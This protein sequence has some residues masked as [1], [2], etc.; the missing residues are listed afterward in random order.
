MVNVVLEII[1][2]KSDY[3]RV[4]LGEAPNQRSPSK[5]V[6]TIVTLHYLTG[7]RQSFGT[8]VENAIVSL[9]EVIQFIPRRMWAILGQ[10]THGRLFIWIVSRYPNAQLFAID[11]KV[12][13]SFKEMNQLEVVAL[14]GIWIRLIIF[15]RWHNQ[16]PANCICMC[17]FEPIFQLV[18]RPTS[19]LVPHCLGLLETCVTRDPMEWIA[20]HKQVSSILAI[21]SANCY[22]LRSV[23]VMAQPIRRGQSTPVLPCYGI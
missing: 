15:S 20:I 22:K 10:S 5:I 11:A 23:L 8:T 17:I 2:I 18:R 6:P 7:L 1:D 3:L 12:F 9:S 14:I 21:G 4:I 19:L 16:R 13:G